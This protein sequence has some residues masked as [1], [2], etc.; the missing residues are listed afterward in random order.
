MHR[1]VASMPFNGLRARRGRGRIVRESFRYRGR[2]CIKAL[3]A[4]RDLRTCRIDKPASLST[5]RLPKRVATGDHRIPK[6]PLRT[7]RTRLFTLRRLVASFF[8]RRER[9][10]SSFDGFEGLCL[11][12]RRDH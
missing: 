6:G 1:K 11:H 3:N 4:S 2:V 7:R 12:L 9:A 5:K 10:R 8:D